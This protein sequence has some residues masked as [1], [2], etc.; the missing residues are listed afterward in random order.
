[1]L[2]I[3]STENRATMQAYREGRSLED[4]LT[5]MWD[6]RATEHPRT[7]KSVGK[8]PCQIYA[9]AKDSNVTSIR[10]GKRGK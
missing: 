1:M 5:E 9:K 7:D 10:A 6:R 4:Y 2:R 3:I 8:W